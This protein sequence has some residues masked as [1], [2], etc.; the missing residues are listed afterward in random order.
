MF[1]YNIVVN[2]LQ[3]K[4][5]WIKLLLT[6]VNDELLNIYCKDLT[7]IYCQDIPGIEN[8]YFCTLRPNRHLYKN[9]LN[10]KDYLSINMFNKQ[11]VIVY[12]KHSKKP[13]VI[14]PFTIT[15]IIIGT[16]F[17]FKFLIIKQN[18]LLKHEGINACLFLT[19]NFNLVVDIQNI[20]ITPHNIIKDKLKSGETICIKSIFDNKDTS[21][22]STT[23]TIAYKSRSQTYTNKSYIEYKRS[24]K[25][26]FKLFLALLTLL[27]TFYK[28][29]DFCD[30]YKQEVLTNY[31]SNIFKIP[32]KYT[33]S[34]KLAIGHPFN[35]FL[36]HN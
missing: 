34:D 8:R 31:R 17:L 16:K 4:A 21:Y 14:D 18:S 2:S 3:E 13:I 7:N 22:L 11:E 10:S 27:D 9:R 33:W 25:L 30:K 32:D 19:D 36:L 20:T 12:D 26:G 1:T 15:T 6:Q 35:I 5:C 28:N 23:Y 24:N 29:T